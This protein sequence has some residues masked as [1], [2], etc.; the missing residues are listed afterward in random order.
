MSKFRGRVLIAR[1]T[2]IAIAVFGLVAGYF[3]G[4]ALAIQLAA[5]CLNQNTA[6]VAAQDDASFLEAR[7]V[8]AGIQDRPSSFCSEA[9]IA[10]FRELVF[11]SDYL[12]DVGRI[13]GGKIDC[14]ATEGGLA[15]PLG[16]FKAQSTQKDG[17]I[18]YNDLVPIRDA[19]LKREGLQM[20]TAYAVFGSASLPRLGSIPLQIAINA[21]DGAH[22]RATD[23][24][25]SDRLIATTDG[26]GRA[27]GTLYATRCSTLNQ[28]CVMATASV[29]DALQG[30]IILIAG[31]TLVLGVLGTLSGLALS[32]LYNR[33]SDHSQQLR[34]AISSDK[35]QLA[36]Q[37]IVNLHS[38]KIVGAEVLARWD[39]EDGNTVPPDTFIKIAEENNFIG[40]LTKMVLRR[41]LHSF[42]DT[43]RNHPNF[44]LSVNV[45]AADL[46]DPK[47]LPM[48]DEILKRT[49]VEAKSLVIEITERS[50]AENAVAMETIRELRRREHSIHIDDFGT[51]YSNLDK[52]LYLFADTIKIDK[53]FT[54]VIGTESVTVAI[55]PQILAMARSLNL[56]V[57]VEGVETEHQSNYFNSV[58][59]KIFAQGWLY[60][61]PV[62]AEVLSHLLAQESSGW[63]TEAD[64]TP[65]RPAKQHAAQRPRIA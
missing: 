34:R 11:R 51:G 27:G 21:K 33:S 44:R 56:D 47:F 49:K 38:G 50:M 25:Q 7:K 3:L 65:I 60:G 41:A 35:V 31:I 15:R 20:G 36:Y 42:A 2:T 4:R 43:L 17:T 24:T 45:S 40:E 23:G 8:L 19:S 59:Q 54:R 48:L 37:P 16:Q 63:V 61:R 12:K 22:E 10:H 57:V 58:G 26:S 30:E 53:A 29:S 9:E 6:L 39:D 14:S 5:N 13:R 55:I 52:L 32:L 18:S 62:S 28:S 1:S 64:V 46:V